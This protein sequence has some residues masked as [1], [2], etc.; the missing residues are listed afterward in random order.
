ML[1]LSRGFGSNPLSQEHYSTP[2]LVI[3][4]PAPIPPPRQIAAI[5]DA[6]VTM[7]TGRSSPSNT[8]TWVRWHLTQMAS[9]SYNGVSTLQ[10][11]SVL[12]FCMLAASFPTDMDRAAIPICRRYQ[13]G[14]KMCCLRYYLPSKFASS[15]TTAI[16]RS[17]CRLELKR[18]NALSAVVYD[19]T[20]GHSS[21]MTSAHTSAASPSRSSRQ[22]SS[23]SAASMSSCEMT[24]KVCQSSVGRACSGTAQAAKRCR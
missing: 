1:E 16:A 3:E 4:A 10:V 17:W 23:A 9:I 21:L 20:T 15:F 22:P 11:G 6:A 24:V 14:D 7:P 2:L 13:R 12:L 8:H 5:I 19:G 18:W